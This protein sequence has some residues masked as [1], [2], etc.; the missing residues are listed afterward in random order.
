MSI[1]SWIKSSLRKGFESDWRLLRLGHVSKPVW[2]FSFIPRRRGGRFIVGPHYRMWQ[3]TK[4]YDEDFGYYE[5]LDCMY[6]KDFKEAEACWKDH[7]FLG[8]AGDMK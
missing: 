5:A 8:Y 1:K 6:F 2:A 3:V 7:F 4:H